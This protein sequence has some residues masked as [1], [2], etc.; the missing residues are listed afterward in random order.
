MYVVTT[1]KKKKTLVLNKC[2]RRSTYLLNSGSIELP[3]YVCTPIA[4]QILAP[5]YLNKLSF[6]PVFVL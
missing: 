5:V 6:P 1:K 4:K 3:M 2:Y